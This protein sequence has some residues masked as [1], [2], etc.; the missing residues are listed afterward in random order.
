ML[1]AASQ[2]VGCTELTVQLIG[3]A[4]SESGNQETTATATA[5]TTTEC[6]YAQ[7]LHWGS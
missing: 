7:R 2:K 6:L 4:R 3:G 5:C 1:P